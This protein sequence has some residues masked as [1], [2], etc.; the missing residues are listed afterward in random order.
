M[1]R[2]SPW[3]SRAAPPASVLRAGSTWTSMGPS[4]RCT[5]STSSPTR[6]ATR[7]QWETLS[8]AG[9]AVSTTSAIPERI[10]DPTRSRTWKISNPNVRNSLGTGRVQVGARVDADPARRSRRRRSAVV[11]PSPPAICGSPPTSRASVEPRTAPEPVS[12]EDGLPRW[13]AAERPRR[14]RCRP[15]VLVRR[16]ARRS[17]RGLAGD[18]GRVR[19]LPA[20]SRR[21]LRSQSST[22]RSGACTSEEGPD[23]V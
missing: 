16:H 1:A 2:S 14:H 6:P 20:H 10:V 12:G 21:L 17:P 23:G 4:T 22:R 11:L 18:A 15:V 5:R 3:V 9:D 19:G 8:A 13:T 7:T